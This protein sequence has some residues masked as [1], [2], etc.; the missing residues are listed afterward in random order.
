[1]PSISCAWSP[2][3]IALRPV[4]GCVRTI[5]C[6][7][8][9]T[10]AFCSAVIGSSPWRR[11]REKSGLWVAPF[12]LVF[13]FL[14]GGEVLL[15]AYILGDSVLPPGGGASFGNI[16]GGRAARLPPEAVGL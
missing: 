13:F 2:R 15:G 6:A 9:G 11:G 12:P 3:K 14:L 5:G 10:L 7:I 8:G 4:S 1:M 16:L